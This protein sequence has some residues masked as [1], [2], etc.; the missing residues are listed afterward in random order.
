MNLKE[1]DLIKKEM[2]TSMHW[3]TKKMVQ[4][5]GYTKKDM[6]L[7]DTCLTTLELSPNENLALLPSVV[8]S[9]LITGIYR[10]TNKNGKTQGIYYHRS[11]LIHAKRLFETLLYESKLCDI[12]GIDL[13]EVK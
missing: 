12:L 8:Y 13:K 10:I 2:P 9:V 11:D 5:K 1:E 4:I 6:Q 3:C 7:F